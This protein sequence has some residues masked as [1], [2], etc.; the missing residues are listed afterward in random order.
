MSRPVRAARHDPFWDLDG[1]GAR[2]LRARQRVVQVLLALMAVS[3]L[4]VVV[5]HVPA[6]DAADLTQG[7]GRPALIGV[8]LAIVAACALVAATRFRPTR[9]G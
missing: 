7:S 5:T 4:A 9:Q 3:V 8:L 2:R 6:V 1:K